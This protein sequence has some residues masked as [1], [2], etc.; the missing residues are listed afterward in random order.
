[1]WPISLDVLAKMVERGEHGKNMKLF[2]SK[3]G[4]AVDIEGISEGEIFLELSH[5]PRRKERQRVSNR[6]H[7]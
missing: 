4:V 6:Y 1:M 5:L 7:P 3:K 2:F